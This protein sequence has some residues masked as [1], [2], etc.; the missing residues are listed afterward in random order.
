VAGGVDEVE[1]PVAVVALV[2]EADGLG[3]DGYAALALELHGVQDLVHPV[4]LGDGLRQVEQPVG[5]GALAVVDVRDY[6]E[7]AGPLDVF[8]RRSLP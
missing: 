6:A 8:H 1:H 7:I 2:E 3:L 4:P 5:E